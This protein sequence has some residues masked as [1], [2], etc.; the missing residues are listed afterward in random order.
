MVFT[1]AINAQETYSR[2]F[3]LDTNA[4]RNY[5]KDM[6]IVNNTI[7]SI[8]TQFCDQDS[9]NPECTILAKFPIRPAC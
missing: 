6:E 7:Y 1:Q 4:S 9:I 5:L 8:S 3:D 2:I